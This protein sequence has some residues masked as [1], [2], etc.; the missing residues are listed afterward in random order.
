[1]RLLDELN[2]AQFNNSLGQGIGNA[3]NFP[4]TAED[5]AIV[6]TNRGLL[7]LWAVEGD[8]QRVYDDPQIQKPVRPSFP[9]PGV[10]PG[11]NG[12]VD[13]LWQQ[14]KGFTPYGIG[15]EGPRTRF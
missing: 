11:I 7:P 9:F 8:V 3:F 10:T 1:M 4:F 15:A 14:K 2:G 13:V 6:N 12:A 5:D